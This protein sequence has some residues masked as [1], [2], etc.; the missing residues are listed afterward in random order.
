MR[1]GLLTQPEDVRLEVD[2][3]ESVAL[4]WYPAPSRAPAALFIPGLGSHRRGEKASYFA[5]RFTAAGRSFASLD[6]RGQGDAD[7]AIRDLTMT[8]MLSDVSVAADWITA[9]SGCGRMVLIG[10]SMGAAV[11]AWHAARRPAGSEALILLAPSLRFPAALI[12]S[13]EPGG[14]EHWRSAGLR[15]IRSEW[16]DVELGTALLDDAARYDPDELPRRLATPTL[17]IHGLRD[18]TIPWQH[19]EDFVRAMPRAAADLFL[20]GAGDHRLTAHKELLFAI[21]SAWL[22]ELNR[23]AG[24]SAR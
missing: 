4:D 23:R 19:S 10:A 5:E 20:V 16:I 12:E 17:L 13:G 3:G 14:L 22:D 24:E 15:R 8:R 6:L 1:P 7:G 21:F 18:R 9:R 11:V 2:C